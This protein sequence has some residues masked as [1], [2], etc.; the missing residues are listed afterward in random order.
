MKTTF[1]PTNYMHHSLGRSALL[2]V[3]L[4]IACFALSP[5]A[6]AVCQDGCNN[7]LFDTFQG[8]DALTNDTGGGN[9]AFGWRSLF[10][11]SDGSFNTGVGAGVLALNNGS[12]N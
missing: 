12:S 2:L 5:Q 9:S 10:S 4:L 7:G 6:R 11:N 3:L 1:L 8:D